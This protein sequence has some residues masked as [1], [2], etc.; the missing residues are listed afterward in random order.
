MKESSLSES[1]GT[2]NLDIGGWNGGLLLDKLS[3][4]NIQLNE[5]ALTLLTSDQFKTLTERQG[6]KITVV[7]VSDL[8]FPSGACMPAIIDGAI[9]RGYRLCPMEL[10]VHFR[11]QYQDQS[12]EIDAVVTQNCAP[13]G[14]ITVAS[15]PISLDKHFPKG[16]YLRNI[17]GRLWLRGYRSDDEHQWNA[18]DL[19][20][21]LIA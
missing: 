9:Q 17:E 18:S 14:S 2:Y 6:V 20:A 4:A 15:E 5:H 21:F 8:G 12:E 13:P 10:A 3:A 1:H 19:F 11:L 16:F 7:S